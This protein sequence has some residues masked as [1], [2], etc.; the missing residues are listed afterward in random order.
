[1]PQLAINFVI[2]LTDDEA[3]AVA[4]TL[5]CEPDDLAAVLQAY[6]PAAVREYADMF[7]G[8][9]MTSIADQRERRLV[10]MLLALPPE[11]FPSDETVARLFNLTVAQGRALLRTTLSRHRNRLKSVMDAAARRFIA[12]CQPSGQGGQ[13]A[14]RFPNAVVIDM[15][16]VQLAAAAAPRAPIRRQSGTFDTYLVSNGA[17]QELQTLYP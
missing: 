5:G 3:A 17:W 16:N 9:A 10:A 12:A 1:M 14:A 15:L 6:A 2:D 8:Q 11:R 13:R 4:D 7:A